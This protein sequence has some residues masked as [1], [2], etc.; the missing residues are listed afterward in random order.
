MKI[1]KK[2]KCRD[3]VLFVVDEGNG[4]TKRVGEASVAK[5]IAEGKLK[6]ATPVCREG[7]KP[8]IRLLDS[9]IPTMETNL[10]IDDF[11][12]ITKKNGDPM[13]LKEM[14]FMEELQSLKSG[15]RRAL[16]IVCMWMFKDKTC[17]SVRG[18]HQSLNVTMTAEKMR[19]F[20][21]RGY[22]RN[23]KL[24]R[25]GQS[26]NICI[27]EGDVKSYMVNSPLDF[28]ATTSDGHS[29]VNVGKSYIG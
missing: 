3:G 16:K 24:V 5:Y 25:R 22:V 29:L 2:I 13:S 9:S 17:Y 8:Y 23:A 15:G 14:R 19:D 18:C 6:D 21:K 7:A 1:T 26:Q 27:T 20:I 28:N 10:C 12:R 4:K 11:M